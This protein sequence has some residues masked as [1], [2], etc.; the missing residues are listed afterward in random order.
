MAEFLN[1]KAT[2]TSAGFPHRSQITLTSDYTTRRDAIR[3]SPPGAAQAVIDG[4]GR[5]SG[6]RN[7][8]VVIVDRNIGEVNLLISFAAGGGTAEDRNYGRLCETERVDRVA[9]ALRDG[10]DQCIA[11][12]QRQALSVPGQR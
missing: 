9:V 10:R 7:A 12:P 11:R 2:G 6:G 1:L 8:L 4:S 3:E 5:V